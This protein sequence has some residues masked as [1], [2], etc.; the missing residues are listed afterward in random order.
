[1]DAPENERPKR[2]PKI[3]FRVLNHERSPTEVAEM[4]EHLQQLEAA[5]RPIEAKV[6]TDFESISGGKWSEKVLNEGIEVV[7]THSARPGAFDGKII[8]LRLKDLS[9]WAK[10]K[11]ENFYNV[12]TSIPQQLSLLIHEITHLF[13]ED[14]N[15]QEY[16]MKTYGDRVNPENLLSDNRPLNNAIWQA[17]IHIHT[18]LLW[19]EVMSRN[20]SAED[21]SINRDV[22][23][24]RA[25][26]YRESYRIIDQLSQEEKQRIV[27]RSLRE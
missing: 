3:S 5:W 17:Q 7:L 16:V 24:N 23:R 27:N 20:C 9:L 1:M 15:D 6:L 12:N 21:M 2:L 4:E 8:R 11:G 25:S 26:V 19:D 18:E 22:A 10:E 13:E 14:S